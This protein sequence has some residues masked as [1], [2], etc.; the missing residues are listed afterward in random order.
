M[1]TLKLKSIRVGKG[2]IQSKLAKEMGT[3]ENTYNRKE[4]G[5]IAF[6]IEEVKKI[7]E[8]LDLDIDQVND[9]FFDN[10]LTN[11]KIV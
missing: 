8:I 2:Y 3:S 9:I 11:T 6:T 5:M 4:L 1:K 7:S 10:Q